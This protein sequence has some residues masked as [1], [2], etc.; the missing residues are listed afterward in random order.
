MRNGCHSRLETRRGRGS[1]TKQEIFMTATTHD[2]N[3][4]LNDLVETCKDSQKGYRTAAEGAKSP[5]LKQLLDELSLERAR[6]AGD[7]QS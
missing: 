5:E 2:F 7:L 3:E 1:P 4:T 6:F